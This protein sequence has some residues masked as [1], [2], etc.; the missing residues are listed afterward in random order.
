MPSF[1]LQNKVAIITGGSRGIGEAIAQAFA[2]AGAKVVVASRKLENVQPVADAINAAGGQALAVACHT[3][4]RAQIQ[5]LVQQTVET[6]GTVDIAVNNAATNPHFGPLLEATDEMWDKT[7]QVNV[8]GY[9]TL[10]QAVAPIM[11]ERGSGKIINI[12]S[13]AGLTPGAGMGV[14]SVTKA[15]VLM[16]TQSLA[17]ELGGRGIQVNAIAPGVIKTKFSTALWSNEKLVKGIERRAGRVGEP[18]DV[19]GSALF[20]ASP[21]SDYVNGAVLVVDGGIEVVSS[22]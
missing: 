13:V 10:C 5:S 9:F 2:G 3:G 14:Y 16:L 7:L 11:L 21:A 18:D 17:Q 4:D 22:I 20:L 15:A 1:D 8:K 19:A 6:F 12:A